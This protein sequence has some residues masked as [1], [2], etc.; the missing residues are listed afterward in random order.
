MAGRRVLRAALAVAPAAAL[1]A[2]FLLLPPATAAPALDR[3]AAAA[4]PTPSPTPSAGGAGDESEP[5][6]EEVAAERERAQALLDE[7]NRRQ[8][9]VTDAQAKLDAATATA[10]LALE[11]YS[12]AV[13]AA[14]TAQLEA[15]RQDQLLLQAQLGLAAQKAI[16][17]RWARAA[18]GDGDLAS[19]PALA[20]IL[21]GGSTDDLGRAETYLQRVGNSKGRA[22]VDYTAALAHQ[23]DVASAA[24]SA[25]AAAQDAALAAKAAKDAADAA[26][27][28]QR[29]TLAALETELAQVQ[30]AAADAETRANNLAAARA[31]ARARSGR[32][33]NGSNAVTGEVGDCRGGDTSPYA[34]G[35]IPAAVLCPVWGTSGHRLR[36]DAAYAFNRL[37]QAYAQ[38]FGEPVCVTDS[39][40]DYATQ[41]RLYATKPNLAAVPGTSNHGWGTATDLCGGIQDFGTPTHRWMLRHAPEF[42]WFHPAWAEPG[43]SRP[44]PWHWE[45]AG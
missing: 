38:E 29:D 2:A 23:A 40:R 8:G 6:P 26:V 18:Y 15:D 7:V 11:Q 42:G 12:G 24:A 14:R 19:N 32:G 36:A 13:V 31:L 28:A 30:D 33:A 43:G 37:S 27:S 3:A 16:L 35:E 44:E 5:S 41:V 25:Q 4:S 21:Q 22:V 9:A 45:F 39:Y 10:S 17:G 1:T 34:N 20:T